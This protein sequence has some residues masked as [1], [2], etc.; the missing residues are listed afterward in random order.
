MEAVAVVCFWPC[1]STS[2]Q[3]QGHPP[4]PK[5]KGGVFCHQSQPSL[6]ASASPQWRA[7]FFN[8]S[9]L[10][11]PETHPALERAC[12]LPCEAGARLDLLDYGKTVR[13][14][15]RAVAFAAASSLERYPDIER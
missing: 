9:Q 15:A 6:S 4:P 5:A 10:R 1:A 14:I 13:R 12:E 11:V 8:F 3:S 7:G 2:A